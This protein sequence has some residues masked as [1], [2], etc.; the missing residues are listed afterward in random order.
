M[1]EDRAIVFLSNLA[2]YSLFQG[3][4]KDMICGG[5]CRIELSLHR[6]ERVRLE[7]K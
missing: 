4:V 6:A 5:F 1:R 3:V 2:E 7:R